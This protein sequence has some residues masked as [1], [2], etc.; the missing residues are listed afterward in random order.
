MAPQAMMA[1]MNRGMS[2]TPTMPASTPPALAMAGYDLGPAA[3]VL[4]ES[5]PG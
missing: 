2:S 3:V 5:R 4:G 1:A